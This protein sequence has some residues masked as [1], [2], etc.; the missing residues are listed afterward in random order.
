MEETDLT[1]VQFDQET[2]NKS[3]SNGFN[4]PEFLQIVID[5]QRKEIKTL[6]RAQFVKDNIAK[7]AEL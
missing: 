6:K 3:L 5:A 7:I 2:F 1:P 4:S